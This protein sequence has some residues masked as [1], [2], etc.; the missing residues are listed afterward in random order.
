[1]LSADT[2]YKLLSSNKKLEADTI[3]KAVSY[4]A[5]LFLLCL[6]LRLVSHCEAVWIIVF[7]EQCFDAMLKLH[8][9][10]PEDIVREE[11]R[12]ESSRVYD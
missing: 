9:N 11:F 7:F 1:M 4:L 5:S 2:F 8:F 10:F 6:I 12:W 3:L